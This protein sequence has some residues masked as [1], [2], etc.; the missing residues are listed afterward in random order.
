MSSSDEEWFGEGLTRRVVW[1]TDTTECANCGSTF[2]L[3]TAHYY[4]THHTAH[5]A[6]TGADSNEVVF[7][8]R[9]CAEEQHS[10]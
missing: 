8:S 1:T 9:S 5:S 4:V 6:S 3:D 7:C 2:D 10:S